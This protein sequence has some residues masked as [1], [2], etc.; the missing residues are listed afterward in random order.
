RS[1]R[2]RRACSPILSRRGSSGDA[3][4]LSGVA[5]DRGGQIQ[6]FQVAR[7]TNNTTASPR[8]PKRAAT[9]VGERNRDMNCSWEEKEATDN[10]PRLGAG[11]AKKRSRQGR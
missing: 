3:T 10:P 2:L 8:N 5:S 4:G 1:P 7:V 6:A 9:V 11:A